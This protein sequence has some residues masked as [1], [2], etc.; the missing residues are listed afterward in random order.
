[1]SI[2]IIFFIQLTNVHTRIR[3]SVQSPIHDSKNVQFTDFPPP[4]ARK[5]KDNPHIERRLVYENPQEVKYNCFL[6]SD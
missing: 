4:P 2:S 5:S 3:Q 1:M 6:F